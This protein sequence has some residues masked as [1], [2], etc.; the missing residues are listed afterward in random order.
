[1]GGTDTDGNG[2][3]DDF[4]DLDGDGFDDT[5]DADNNATPTD[6]DGGTPLVMTVDQKIPIMMV[7]LIM[8]QRL[9]WT[10]MVSWIQKM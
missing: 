6:N 5:Y 7:L 8:V 10:M 2:V 9:M 1:M 3:I 4:N